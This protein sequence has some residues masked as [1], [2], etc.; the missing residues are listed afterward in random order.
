MQADRSAIALHGSS[1]ELNYIQHLWH[2]GCQ[3]S[4]VE[5]GTAIARFY[6]STS[7]LILCV[8]CCPTFKHTNNILCYL[9]V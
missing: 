3:G 4:S 2:Q 7:K 8:G 5:G 9:Y 6:E 1:T